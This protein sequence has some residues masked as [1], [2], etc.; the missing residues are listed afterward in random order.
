MNIALKGMTNGNIWEEKEKTDYYGSNM[1]RDVIRPGFP[2]RVP[3]LRVLETYVLL[4]RE[5]RFGMLS[6]PGFNRA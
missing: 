6:V 3:V 5:I 4:F 1:C 2:R